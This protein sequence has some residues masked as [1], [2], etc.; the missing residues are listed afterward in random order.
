MHITIIIP[1]WQDNRALSTLLQD[2]QELNPLPEQVIVVDGAADPACQLLC[3]EYGAEW[4]SSSA[5]RGAQLDQG[6]RVVTHGGVFWFLHAD[7]RVVCKDVLQSIKTSIESGAVGGYFAFRFNGERSVWLRC[8][9]QLTN[10][11]T[12]IGI[13][14]G[15]QGLFMS[16]V[17]YQQ[18]GGYSAQPLFEEVSLVKKLRRIGYFAKLKNGLSTSSR[19]W[20]RDGWLQ[21]TLQNRGLALAYACGVPVD[22]LYRWYR[23]H[24]MHSSNT[25][26]KASSRS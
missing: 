2:L 12:Q 26:L 3:D 13:P 5:C 8:F 9:E 6:A 25:S 11:R 4:L 23:R 21:R 18:A 17:A 7:S 16:Q 1:A 19:R 20:E 22:R 24:E 14:Y 10:W 15:D